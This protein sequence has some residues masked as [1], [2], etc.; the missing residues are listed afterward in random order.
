MS[1]ILITGGA[2][3][4]KSTFAGNLAADRAGGGPVWF[5]ATA[6]PLDADMA[7]RIAAH[8]AERPAGWVTVEAP[9]G[10]A[11]R[12]AEAGPPAGVVL[13]DCLTL[14]VSNVLLAHPE[15]AA[16]ADVWPTVAAEVDGIVRAS[17]GT[18][19]TI[20]VTNEVGLGVVPATPLG[21]VYRDLLGAANQRLAA[22]AD[23]VFLVVS[24]IPLQIKSPAADRPGEER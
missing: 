20:V 4:G 12:I 23:Q 3:A 21:R 14:L 13:I 10:V 5:V 9:R 15:P 7:A 19:A 22:A 16:V 18:A 1:L 2:R 24:G 6:E 8:R 17:R 11:D